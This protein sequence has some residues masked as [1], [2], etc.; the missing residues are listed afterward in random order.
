VSNHF[1]YIANK[2]PVTLLM[3]GV[4]LAA[5]GLFSEGDSFDNAPLAQTGRR[6]TQLDM[7]PFRIDSA[8][9]PALRG[10]LRLRAAPI[11]GPWCRG[12]GQPRTRR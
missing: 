11:P 9:A 10:W 4:G 7:Q 1:K 2:F 5:K 12:R 6:T 3:V 8:M